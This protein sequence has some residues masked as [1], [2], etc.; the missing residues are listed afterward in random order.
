MQ[1][2]PA[3]YIFYAAILLLRR[4]PFDLLTFAIATVG[5]QKHHY[6]GA[7]LRG[8][9]SVML[10][11]CI[12]RQGTNR[13]RP[14]SSATP[15]GNPS[16]LSIR[17]Q[18]Q[19]RVTIGTPHREQWGHHH[20][21]RPMSHRTTQPLELALEAAD[22]TAWVVSRV[23]VDVQH[24]TIVFRKLH[25]LHWHRRAEPRLRLALIEGPQQRARYQL[26]K[27]A[28]RPSRH[29]G[30]ETKLGTLSVMRVVCR[31][32]QTMPFLS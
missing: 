5:L 9:L 21:L 32:V 14:I 22:V 31:S 16:F 28:G 17:T 25:S 13:A 10:V 3:I 29:S 19:V 27:I 4:I 20:V 6:G 2:R 12:K 15:L 11:V 26:V 7:H 23:V 24:S 8:K 30:E 1:V 18:H